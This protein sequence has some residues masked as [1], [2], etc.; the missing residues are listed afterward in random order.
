MESDQAD[1][2][3]KP[4]SKTIQEFEVFP[5][6]GGGEVWH[7]VAKNGK[8]LDGDEKMKEDARFNKGYE[9]RTKEATKE[10]AKLADPKKQAKQEAEDERDISKIL[11]AERFTNPRRERLRGQPVLAFDFGA[12]PDYKP[13]SMEER[14]AQSLAGSAVGGRARS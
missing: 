9:E 7:L 14:F 1:S 12:N 6:S 13:K 11:R 4:D 3:A 5:I 2:K 8:P 10:Q